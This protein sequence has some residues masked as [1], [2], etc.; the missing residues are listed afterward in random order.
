MIPEIWYTTDGRTD[1]QKKL[2]TEVG[3]PPKNHLRNKRGPTEPWRS[4][5][6]IF[7]SAMTI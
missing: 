2:H 3:A 6:N 1:E 7:A 4:T 5:E